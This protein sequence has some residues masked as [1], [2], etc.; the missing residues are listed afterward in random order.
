MASIAAGRVLDVHRRNDRPFSFGTT[1]EPGFRFRHGECLLLGLEVAGK[2][3]LRASSIASAE[4]IGCTQ[5][6]AV[7]LTRRRDG[8]LQRA[9]EPLRCDRR[10]TGPPAQSSLNPLART[11]APKSA[12]SGTA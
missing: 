9:A 2:P 1:R 11:N 12:R 6:R 10:R 4:F 7:V 3:P 5:A 8:G